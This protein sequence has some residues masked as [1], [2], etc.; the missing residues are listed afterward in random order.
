MAAGP[1]PAMCPQ[2]PES[3][4]HPGLHKKQCGQQGKG[5]DPAPLLCAGVAS[6]GVWHPDVKSSVQD[7]CKLVGVHPEE[8][9]KNDPRGGAPGGQAE[10][11]GLSN[12]VKRKLWGDLMAAFQ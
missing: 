12:L 9:C 1:E 11:V 2:S 5:G 6:S 7:R 3:Q 8:G 4:L 10:R